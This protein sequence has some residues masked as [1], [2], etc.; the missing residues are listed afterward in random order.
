MRMGLGLVAMALTLTLGQAIPFAP[1]RSAMAAEQ[2]SEL[3]EGEVTNIDQARSRVTIRSRDGTVYEF[4]ASAETLEDL[5]I[6]DRIE[7]KRRS[8]EQ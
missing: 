4:E 1:A 6:G 5:K 8:A 2:A 3:V 7:A